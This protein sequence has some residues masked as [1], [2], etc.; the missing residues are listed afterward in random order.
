MN[1]RLNAN[2]GPTSSGRLLGL[3]VHCAGLGERILGGLKAGAVDVVADLDGAVL[4]CGEG[5]VVEV[6]GIKWHAVAE[7]KSCQLSK[8]LWPVTNR[9]LE[10]FRRG[11]ELFDFGV[12]ELSHDR[13]GALVIVD[14]GSVRLF[15]G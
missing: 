8:R 1:S 11:D 3:N 4:Q 6:G 13:I 7:G 12:G 14:G 2:H 10:R 15:A 9:R 5:Y